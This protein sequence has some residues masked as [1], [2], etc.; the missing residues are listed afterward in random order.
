MAK[1]KMSQEAFVK[2]AIVKL[3]TGN[4]KG[5]HSVFSG[6]NEAFKRYY[7]DADPIDTTNNLAE[8]GKIALRPVK[9]GVMLYLPEEAPEFADKAELALRKMGLI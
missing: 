2:L 8:T 9:R 5:I 6:F 7:G 3:R 4:F 1:D